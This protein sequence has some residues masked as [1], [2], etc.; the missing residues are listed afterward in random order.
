M[1]ASGEVGPFGYHVVTSPDPND[2]V[3]WL[4]DN[5]YRIT[6][7]MIPLIKAYTDDGHGS[8]WR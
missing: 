3:A 4:R 8:F 5:G 2:M 1:L 6:D 7:E